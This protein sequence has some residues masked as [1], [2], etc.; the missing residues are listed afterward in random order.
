MLIF[1]NKCTANRVAT[2]DDLVRF[3]IGTINTR[4]EGELE[5]E[6]HCKKDKAHGD[7]ITHRLWVIDSYSFHFD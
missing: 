7:C 6:V 3:V 5:N 1:R 2:L 4:K